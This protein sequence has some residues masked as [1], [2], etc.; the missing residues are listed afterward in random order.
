[1][2]QKGQR[3][4]LDELAGSWGVDLA[5]GQSWAILTNDGGEFAVVPE[6]SALARLGAGAARLLTYRVRRKAG[7]VCA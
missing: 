2:A 3:Y 6:P 5:T 4:T 7:R 1:M